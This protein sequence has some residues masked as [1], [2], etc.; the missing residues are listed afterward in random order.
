MEA[1][2]PRCLLA[3]WLLGRECRRATGRRSTDWTCRRWCRSMSPVSPSCP[4]GPE[5][6]GAR[7]RAGPCGRDGW[8]N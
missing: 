6:G 8:R 1:V 4:N 5:R 3:R 2:P 7:F